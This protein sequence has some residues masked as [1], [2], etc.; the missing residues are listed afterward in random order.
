MPSPDNKWIHMEIC[1]NDNCQRKSRE[2]VKMKK[3]KKKKLPVSL[4]PPQ[5]P[6]GLSWDQTWGLHIVKSWINYQ[7]YGTTWR[8]PPFTSIL[9]I[10]N[11]SVFQPSHS[12]SV[13]LVKSVLPHRVC[14]AYRYAWLFWNMVWVI[15][16][17]L[18]QLI[19]QKLVMAKL[20]NMWE[21]CLTLMGVHL[22]T[23]F[24]WKLKNN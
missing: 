13:L 3:K 2:L 17:P 5:M 24:V 6:D 8:V 19:L 22:I 10:H 15:W 7:R 20:K 18:G 21:F 14:C 16:K 4:C 23:G 9:L 1:C 11:S 12:A